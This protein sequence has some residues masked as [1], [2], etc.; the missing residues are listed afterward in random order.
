MI[1]TPKGHLNFEGGSGHGLLRLGL[2]QAGAALEPDLGGAA[3][4]LLHRAPF[5][6]APPDRLTGYEGEV[7]VIE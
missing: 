5:P 2:E 7:S 3:M 4:E 1:L 6:Q